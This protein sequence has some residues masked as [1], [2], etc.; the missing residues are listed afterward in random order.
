MRKSNSTIKAAR[1]MQPV[2]LGNGK[3]YTPIRTEFGDMEYELSFQGE[4]VGFATSPEQARETLN[5]VAYDFE[6]GTIPAAFDLEPDP[7]EEAAEIAAN[8]IPDDVVTVER[9]EEPELE[10]IIYACGNNEIR[11]LDEPDHRWIGQLTALDRGIDIESSSGIA[12]LR[13][14]SFLLEHP[15][16]RRLIERGTP[17]APITPFVADDEASFVSYRLGNVEVDV[18]GFGRF[19][20]LVGHLSRV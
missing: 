3:A 19:P 7:T 9:C 13:A 11:I 17:P 10:S 6:R 4:L 15:D 2:D 20:G 14:L 5:E 12:D 16:I 8:A 1:R 18:N